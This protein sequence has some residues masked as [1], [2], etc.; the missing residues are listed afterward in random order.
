MILPYPF[1]YLA[2]MICADDSGCI[3]SVERTQTSF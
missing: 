1:D 3:F 2:L